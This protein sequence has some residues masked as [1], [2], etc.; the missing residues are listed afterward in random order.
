MEARCYHGGSGR[1][2]MN[3]I[4]FHRGDAIAALLVIAFLAAIIASRFI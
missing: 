4:R 1:T 2:R 3:Q